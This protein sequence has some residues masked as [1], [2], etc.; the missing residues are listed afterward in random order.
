MLAMRAMWPWGQRRV[1]LGM[2]VFGHTVAVCIS[3]L[4]ILILHVHAP[5]YVIQT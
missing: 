1:G 5:L 4:E 3:R 2:G